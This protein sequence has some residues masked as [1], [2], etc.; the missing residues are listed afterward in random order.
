MISSL[1]PI[2]PTYTSSLST[3]TSCPLLC[4]LCNLLPNAFSVKKL[5]IRI[6]PF[7]TCLC[8]CTCSEEKPN[9]FFS[10]LPSVFWASNSH[11][12]VCQQAPV[13]SLF[14]DIVLSILTYSVLSNALKIQLHAK[15]LNMSQN[16]PL[17]MF[18]L[19]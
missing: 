4:L 1:S 6:C 3:F 7:Y 8:L 13:L 10:F 14:V 18:S 12:W 16:N 2:P 11:H 9:L 15:S 5:Q 17:L 19:Y